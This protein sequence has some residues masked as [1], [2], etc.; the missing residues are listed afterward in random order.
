MPMVI[1]LIAAGFSAAAGMAGATALIGGTITAASIAGGLMVAGAALTVIGTLTGNKT[2]SKWGGI[3]GLAGGVTTLASGAFGAASSAAADSAAGS[4]GAT[5]SAASEVGAQSIA[6]MGGEA[7]AAA[8]VSGGDAVIGNAM[9]PQAIEHAAANGLADAAAP[10]LADAAPALADAGSSPVLGP[11]A[12]VDGSRAAS[13]QGQQALFGTS[14]ADSVF[15]AAAPAPTL[16]GATGLSATPAAPSFMERVSDAGK[17]AST[18]MKDNKELVNVGGGMIQGAMRSYGDQAAMK[19]RMELQEG[20]DA[21]QRARI[22]A[23]L[24]GLTMPTYHR[25][26]A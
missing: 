23:S 7:A 12:I 18:W 14:G 5:G 15:G 26:G 4:V 6:N 20:Y 21:R 24:K 16:S 8:P 10:A 9:G 11:Q 1:P 13:A 2:L 19:Q 3:L 17:T 25:P 22:N